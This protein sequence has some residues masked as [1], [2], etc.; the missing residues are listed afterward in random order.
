MCPLSSLYTERNLLSFRL[1]DYNN[2]YDKYWISTIIKSIQYNTNIQGHSGTVNYIITQKKQS[3][4][5]SKKDT[6]SNYK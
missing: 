4:L 1:N 2:Q 5:S 6:N 3:K